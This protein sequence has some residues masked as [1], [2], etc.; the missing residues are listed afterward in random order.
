MKYAIFA[1]LRGGFGGATF[2]YVDEFDSKDEALKAAYDMAVAVY[3]SYEGY[4]SYHGLLD[5]EG[6]RDNLRRL[7]GEEP[8]EDDVRERY[9][10]EVESWIDYRVE[11]YEEGKDYE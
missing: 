5:W 7:F 10:E 11:G 9:L 3:E 4:E 6:V 1:G 2:Q 8:S